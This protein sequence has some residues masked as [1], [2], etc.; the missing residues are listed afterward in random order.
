M[1]YK[2]K[3]KKVQKKGNK[4]ITEWT[5]DIIEDYCP[6]IRVL[7]Y[8]SNLTSKEE[9]EVEKGKAI[10]KGEYILMLNPILTEQIESKYVEFPDDIE[11]R[12]KIAS[13]SHL[14]VSEA[15][16]RLRD[17]LIHEISAKRHKIEINEETLLQRLILTKYLKRREKKRAFEQLKQAIFV[18]QQ[19]GIIL[20]H[21]KTVGKYGQTKYIFE[22]NK[23]F[24]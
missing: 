15:V 17:W 22:L 21:E 19:L 8:Y 10:V 18:S 16:R 1:R 7:K 6:M 11:Y 4:W 20:R 3:K 2:R 23:D 24:E 14:S 13:G 9:E 5:T 12:T